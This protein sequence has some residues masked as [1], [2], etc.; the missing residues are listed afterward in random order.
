MLDTSWE[1]SWAHFLYQRANGYTSCSYQR[2]LNDIRKKSKEKRKEKERKERKGENQGKLF[3]SFCSV[4][5]SYWE[6]F[7]TIFKFQ[8]IRDAPLPCLILSYA[9]LSFLNTLKVMYCFYL[10]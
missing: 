10:G 3:Y 7:I 9:A 4:K 6:F 5:G 1:S 8:P 2:A